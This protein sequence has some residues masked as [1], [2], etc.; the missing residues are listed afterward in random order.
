MLQ[1]QT[2]RRMY[3]HYEDIYEEMADYEMELVSTLQRQR[4]GRG[5]AP[6]SPAT[7]FRDTGFQVAETW[8]NRASDSSAGKTVFT[9]CLLL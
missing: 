5:K 3:E 4:R 6:A 2:L 1:N 9:P 7:R 8:R